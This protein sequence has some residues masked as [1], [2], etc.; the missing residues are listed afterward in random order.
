[1]VLGPAVS[2][3]RRSEIETGP[4]RRSANGTSISRNSTMV[5]GSDIGTTTSLTVWGAAASITNGCKAWA[6]P[7]ALIAKKP[8]GPARLP[9]RERRA[10]RPAQAKQPTG[11][12][13]WLRVDASNPV[14]SIAARVLAAI[15]G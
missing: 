7:F 5:T 15:L 11:A 3:H 12:V 9:G 6:N 14:E 8:E 1:M 4:D 10:G 13:D 2:S